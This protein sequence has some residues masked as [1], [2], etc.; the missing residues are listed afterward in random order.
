MS[1]KC[2]IAAYYY[3]EGLVPF[4]RNVI[5]VKLISNECS[6]VTHNQDFKGINTPEIESLFSKKA[7][8]QNHSISNCAQLHNIKAMTYKISMCYLY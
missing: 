8:R 3:F 5:Q 6:H 2:H 7:E 4:Y 1:K